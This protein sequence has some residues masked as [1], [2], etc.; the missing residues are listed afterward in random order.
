[1]SDPTATFVV[2]LKNEVSGPARDAAGALERLQA[3]IDGDTKALR[4]MEA[5]QKR[6]KAGGM[7]SSD[8]AKSLADRITA[9]KS[10]IAANQAQVIALGGAFATT[11]KKAGGFG[12][13]LS[14][15]LNG[16]LALP[17]PIAAIA[18]AVLALT[19]ATI[20]A[21]AILV[22]YGI[23]QADARR[24]ELL[25]LEGLTALRSM[26]GAATESATALQG[27]I[28]RTSAT[29]ATS[30]GDVASLATGLAHARLQGSALSNTLQA[31]SIVEAAAGEEGVRRLRGR[32]IADARAG[33]SARAL[34]DIESR[35]GAIA[36]RR[37]LSLDVQRQKFG[38]SIDALFRDVNVDGFLEG[39]HQITDLFSQNTVTGRALK[40][41]VTTLV[42]PLIDGLT[43]AAPLARRFFQGMVIAVQEITIKILE[44][45]L[46]FRRTF[47]GSDILSGIDGMTIALDAGMVAVGALVVG[48]VALAAV[49]GAALAAGNLFI[50]TG[51]AIAAVIGGVVYAIVRGISAIS[52]WFSSGQGERY[53]RSLVDG[54]VS[55]L[56][57]GAVRVEREIS[58]LASTARHAIEDSLGIHSPSRVFAELG[59]QV[60]RGFALGVERAAPVAAAAVDGMAGGAVPSGGRGEMAI[61]IGDVH[62]NA[63]GGDAAA[64]A[65]GLVEALV[66]ALQGSALSR[67]AA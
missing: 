43:A 55:G 66:R 56:H 27:A 60:P 3:R 10:A 58:S 61:S 53:A 45:R 6:L 63:Q 23:A 41:L 35:F 29:T 37:M 49:L 4:A 11:K 38:E 25:R 12:D 64:I 16:S 42:Q 54:L 13:T 65:D 5:A 59:M 14:S 22:Q 51:L 28:D 1:V 48:V 32:L 44:L 15:V 2:D 40:T 62:V 20:G 52:D 24:S 31:L 50:A 47:G 18:G 46:W 7:A 21:I 39:L 36:R 67:G 57:D 30:R 9:Q 19:A 26:Y 34:G 8:A 17:G 33:R